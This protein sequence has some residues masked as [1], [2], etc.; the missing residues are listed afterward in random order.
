MSEQS[1]WIVWYGDEIAAIYATEALALQHVEDVGG[2]AVDSTRVE[3]WTVYR[4]VQ[5]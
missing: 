1:V 3:E 5:T 4:N 2:S